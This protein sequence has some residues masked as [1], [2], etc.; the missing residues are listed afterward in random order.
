MRKVVIST[1]SELESTNSAAF[2]RNLS[3][4]NLPTAHSMYDFP[5]D[6]LVIKYRDD[7]QQCRKLYFFSD[8]I[9]VV[10]VFLVHHS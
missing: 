1:Q 2:I 7:I 6:V 4:T 9:R 3:K 10:G 8:K 5:E